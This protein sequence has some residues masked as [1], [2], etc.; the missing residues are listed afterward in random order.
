MVVSW[1]RLSKIVH[2]PFAAFDSKSWGS[3]PNKNVFKRGKG[4]Y[5][6]AKKIKNLNVEGV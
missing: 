5:I 6:M 2:F 3:L 4:P 1:V